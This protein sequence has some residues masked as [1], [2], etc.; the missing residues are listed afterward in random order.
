[1]ASIAVCAMLSAGCASQRGGL[2][3][4]EGGAE[5][6]LRRGS[7]WSTLKVRPPHVIGPRVT[8]RMTKGEFS[9][10]IDGSP[11]HLRVADDGIDGSGPLGQV[12]IDIVEGAGQTLIEGT[13]N[14]TRVHFTVTEQS[15]RG[16]IAV[17]QASTFG[18]VAFCQYT[19][20][21]VE[22]DGARSGISICDGL[23]EETRLEVPRAV[24]KW[25][26]RHELVVVLLAL[27]SSPPL[28]SLERE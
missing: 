7:G 9:G 24:Q 21:R 26:T 17:R 1:M 8:L 27:L 12:S 20:D 6:G 15:L 10:S 5:V 18:E 4:L 3:E 22:K 19:L 2:S 16:A 11:V 23:P 28:T 13:W 25:L 14:A